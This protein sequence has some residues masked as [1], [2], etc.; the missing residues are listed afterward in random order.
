VELK[1]RKYILVANTLYMTA[2]AFL[3][4]IY[5]LFVI[6]NNIEKYHAG[7]SWA[8]YTILAG[9][10]MLFFSVFQKNQK[11]LKKFLITGYFIATFSTFCYLFVKEFYHLYII[12]TLHA[13]AIG[14]LTPALRTLYASLETKG[15]ES[16][17][18]AQFDAGIFI[19]GG[20]ATLV[21][22]FIFISTS[23][24]NLIILMGLTQL[25]ASLVSCKILIK[26]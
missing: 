3:S 24:T 10:L 20:V 1:N 14:M 11:N 4:P 2:V 17:Q 5:A 21:G 15:K 9:I 8:F 19:L 22:T 12:Q 6:D 26:K 18:W 16:T 23:F 7:F 13:I 25:L